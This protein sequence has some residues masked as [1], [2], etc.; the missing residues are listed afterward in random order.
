[1]RTRW[2]DSDIRI[3]RSRQVCEMHVEYDGRAFFLDPFRRRHHDAEHAANVEI[4]RKTVTRPR[5]ARAIANTYFRFWVRINVSRS[6]R[7]HYHRF[8][9]SLCNF[10]LVSGKRDLARMLFPQC[11]RS[12]YR[13]QLCEDKNK[14]QYT[15]CILRNR[16]K[17]I[18]HP[19]ARDRMDFS[20]IA[21][22]SVRRKRHSENRSAL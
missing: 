13:C 6:R 7:L 19:S 16:V 14:F 10:S 22:A 5:S 2:K 3:L 11:W 15:E 9:G 8:R 4:T 17:L 18:Q 1:M 20:N 12:A 21:L